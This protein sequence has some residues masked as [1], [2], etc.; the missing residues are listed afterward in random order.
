MEIRRAPH[1]L[2]AARQQGSA[3]GCGTRGDLAVA[4]IRALR[5]RRRAGRGQQPPLVLAEPGASGVHLA[6]PVRAQRL[7]DLGHQLGPLSPQQRPGPQADPLTQ[8]FGCPGQRRRL[9]G[10]TLRAPAG[11]TRPGTGSRCACCG[12]PGSAPALAAYYGLRRG[13]LE[14]LE[15][16]DLD[17]ATRRLHVRGDVKSDDSDR[18]IVIDIGTA[19]VLRAWHERQLFERLEWDSAW[20]M[21]KMITDTRPGALRLAQ[22][23]WPGAEARGFEPRKGANPNRIS[24]AAP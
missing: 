17:P 15:W 4:R 21:A 2:S 6:E 1:G 18:V 8:P 12:M 11:R 10:V 5:S 3:A 7:A 24:S 19:E 20:Q 22:S 9:L 14:H 16:A 13:E 23:P